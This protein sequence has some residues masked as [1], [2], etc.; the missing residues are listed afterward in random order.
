MALSG[1]QGVRQD[2]VGMRSGRRLLF[3][4][5]GEWFDS[6]RRAWHLNWQSTG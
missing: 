5:D 2:N 4:C 3:L 1:T 6:E